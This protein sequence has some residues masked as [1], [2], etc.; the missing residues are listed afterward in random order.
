MQNYSS[1]YLDDMNG[2]TLLENHRDIQ[3]DGG[4]N[5]FCEESDEF[6]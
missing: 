1:V 5:L 6:V 3:T 2:Y 4:L